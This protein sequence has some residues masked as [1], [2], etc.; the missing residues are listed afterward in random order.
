[1]FSGKRWPGCSGQAVL[2]ATTSHGA[3]RR[4]HRA[5]TAARRRHG[6]NSDWR[7]LDSADILTMPDNWEY[8]WFAAWPGLHC[9][10]S[11]LIDPRSPSAS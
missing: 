6:R 9:V 1:V 8:P 5:A 10:A 3:G 2:T 4:P 7:L 11:A